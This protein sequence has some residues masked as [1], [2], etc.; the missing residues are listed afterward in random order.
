[1]DAETKGLRFSARHPLKARAL[2]R[3]GKEIAC[4]ATS[5]TPAKAGVQFTFAPP[6][7]AEF[8]LAPE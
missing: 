5:V 7:R 1:M 6:A 4:L 8:R 3:R 2:A